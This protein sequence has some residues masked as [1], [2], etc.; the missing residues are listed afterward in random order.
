VQI[1]IYKPLLFKTIITI[2]CA[3]LTAIKKSLHDT[4][5]TICSSGGD[6]LSLSPQLKRT[7]HH[8]SAHIHWLVSI[9]VQ[10]ESM[11]GSVPS[12]STWRNSILF[13]FFIHASM[14]PFCQ[15][16]PLLPSVIQQQNWMEC[17]FSLYC[18]T[19]NNFPWFN[20]P[21]S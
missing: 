12:L 4:L 18:H 5:V 21:T 10:R 13:L 1:L 6:P 20:G 3:F 14:T 9:N 17:W 15:T 16:A 8:L 7:T 2:T 11:N 19:D